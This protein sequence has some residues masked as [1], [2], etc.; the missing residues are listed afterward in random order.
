M[1]K[2]K[3]IARAKKIRKNIKGT[4]ERLRVTVFRSVQ[5]IYAQIIDDTQGITLVSESDVRLEKGTKTERATQVGETL[6]KK[7][8]SKKI[9]KVVFDKGAFK[10]HGRVAALAE[11]L[12]KGGLDF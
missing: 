4:P 1:L 8:L 12:R 9:S 5:H 7:A 11:G 6:A 3:R 2:G 10:Y